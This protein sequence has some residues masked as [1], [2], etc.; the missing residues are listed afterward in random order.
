[1]NRIK[2]S[3]ADN[4]I[5]NDS[6]VESDSDKED[7]LESDDTDEESSDDESDDDVWILFLFYFKIIEIFYNLIGIF[8]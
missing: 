5:E 2:F 8:K 6:D 3:D 7:N 4:E 1:M